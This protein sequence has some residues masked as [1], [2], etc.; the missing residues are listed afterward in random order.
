MN[1]WLPLIAIAGFAALPPSA[2]AQNPA[3]Y[4][5]KPIRVIVPST[6]GSPPDLV[7]RIIGEKLTAA[8]GKPLVFDNRPGATG[9]IGLEALARSPADGYTLGV[10]SQPFVINASL[11]AKMPYDTEKDLAAVALVNWSYGILSVRAASDLKSVADLVAAAKARPGELKFSGMNAT[12]SHMM[13]ELFNREAGVDIRH[14]PYTGA[15]A[16]TLA[17]L[18]GDVDMIF[19]PAGVVSPHIRS[20]KV[21]A[22]ATTAP[23]RIAA[24]PELPTFVEL[25]YPGVQI[26]DWQGIVAPAGTPKPVI[27]RLYAEIAKAASTPDVKARLEALGMEPASA[28]PEEFAAHIHS[29]MQRWGKFVRET[30][31][32]T[33]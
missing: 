20:G 4:P 13:G 8:L 7:G 1:R 28:G 9:I 3:P 33:D 25:G 5:V 27:A 17:V 6:P 11:V 32:R 10:M 14:I 15:P 30:G 24:F 18:A 26:R 12:A 21:R 19:G 31:I 16:S 2:G 29:E 23:Q 22:L